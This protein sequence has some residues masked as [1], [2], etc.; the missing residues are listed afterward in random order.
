MYCKVIYKKSTDRSQ[1]GNFVVG[2]RRICIGQLASSDILVPEC[3]GYEPEV[4]AVIL[5]SEDTKGWNIVCG[6]DNY[7]VFVN[8]RKVEIACRL[9]NGDEISFSYGEG[10]PMLVLLFEELADCDYD[11]RSGVIY[12]RKKSISL[13]IWISSLAASA[14]LLVAF[15]SLIKDDSLLKYE[16]FSTYENSVFQIVTD[17]LFLFENIGGELVEIESLALE[18][19][20]KGT[21]FLTDEGLLV[22]A[23]HCI[24]P[25]INDTQW[26]GTSDKSGMSEALS[27]ATRAETRNRELGVERYSV[28]SHSIVLIGDE[29]LDLYSYDFRMN[30]S[31]D[32]ILSLGDSSNPIYM[33]TILP[34]A[35]RRDMELG[36]FAY[37]EVKEYKGDISLATME[38]IRSF[39][40]AKEKDIVVMGYPINDNMTDMLNKLEGMCQKIEISDDSEL[41]GC[42]QMS[43]GI[44]YGYSGGPV[45]VRIEGKGIAE[46]KLKVIGIVS[47]YDTNAK[48][49]IF[50]S[51]P[52]TE[53]LLLHSQG[54]EIKD[55]TF[56]YRR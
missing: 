42:I 27:M 25:W 20:E 51:V 40:A 16:D 33:R 18:K 24:E 36:D 7:D 38:H 49:S 30:R 26:N 44:S 4:F 41:E 45:F 31:R 28:H 50:W 23:R 11:L 32:K 14:A 17:S 21:C 10:S 9:E 8:G 37:A 19:V 6:T 46:D 53:I 43:G 39:N 35:T 54:G 3:N 2:Q 47:K 55:E 15:I 1:I 34:V 22:T 12:G 13:I 56:L 29:R 52:S 5:A 48:H